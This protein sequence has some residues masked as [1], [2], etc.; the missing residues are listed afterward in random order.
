MYDV[1]VRGFQ[2]IE[3]VRLTIDGFTAVLGRSNI[4]KSALV[5]AIKCALTNAA[6]T[7]FVRHNPA[8][9]ARVV[10]KSKACRCQATVHLRAEGFD[11]LWEKGDAVNRYTLNGQVYDKPGQGIPD[12]LVQTGLAPLKIGDSAAT[13][14]V[15]DQFFPIFL[16]N[17]SGPAA[18]EAISDV[19]RLDRINTATRLVEKDRRE[20]QAER[21]V[22]EKEQVVLESRLE[23]FEG[24]DAACTQVECVAKQ[25]EAVESLAQQ[26]HNIERFQ[27]SSKALVG[28]IRSIWTIEALPV[29][30]DTD[31]VSKVNEHKQ[32]GSFADTLAKRVSN[33]KGIQWVE[34]FLQM[35]P[36]QNPLGELSTELES[37]DGWVN[38][39]RTYRD[40]FIGLESIETLRVED[41]DPIQ[42]K[43]KQLQTLQTQAAKLTSLESV[44]SRLEGE[45]R[46]LD[47]ELSE[48]T[49]DVDGLGV[50]PT[51]TQPVAAASGHL[52][53]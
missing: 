39:L 30:D 38:R 26:A 5:R 6:G 9:C 23:Q 27:D 43:L 10:A 18:A 4:G 32:I 28:R 48:I 45:I 15:S 31:L 17:Q 35:V 52:H 42:A 37:L 16:L 41:P 12:F 14:Q 11:L 20:I 24:L 3:H 7:A 13:L 22:L 2:S 8:K 47:G 40:R 29:P 21:K 53:A 36:Q 50:C 33:F 46:K 51:C 34:S 44:V 1:E 19:A 49:T 25:L